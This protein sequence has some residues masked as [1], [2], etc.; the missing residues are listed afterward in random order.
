[1]TVAATLIDLEQH[2]WRALSGQA[3]DAG[4]F[5][6]EI[7]D[8]TVTMLLPGGL[9]ITDRATALASLRPGSWE[10]FELTDLRV[11]QPSTDVGLVT[12]AATAQRGGTR[13]SA[14]MSSLYVWRPEGWRL[15]FHQQTPR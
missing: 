13:Y 5:Y 8:E 15:A 3:P 10:S 7:L 2:G 4:R 9:V 12:Y 14:L 6:G 1:M 11:T